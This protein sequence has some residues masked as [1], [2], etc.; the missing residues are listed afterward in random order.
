M[1]RHTLADI[2]KKNCSQ[3]FR[4]YKSHR[5]CFEWE[6]VVQDLYLDTEGLQRSEEPAPISTNAFMCTRKRHIPEFL[7][8]GICLH[9][10][11]FH[12]I[13]YIYLQFHKHAS[14]Q[15]RHLDP[16]DATGSAAEHQSATCA[17]KSIITVKEGH[18]FLSRAQRV[19]G[20]AGMDALSITEHRPAAT[21]FSCTV[22]RWADLSGHASDYKL[23]QITTTDTCLAKTKQ[24]SAAAKPQRPVN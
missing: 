17:S 5:K 2:K 16:R 6:D 19:T 18:S 4:L 3:R 23:L 8:V 13:Y 10:P 15:N 1:Q 11:S 22:Q 20:A 9:S 14:I 7:S 12:Y 21:I 24:N